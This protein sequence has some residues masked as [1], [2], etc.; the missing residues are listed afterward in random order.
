MKSG[1]TILFAIGLLFTSE[2]HGQSADRDLV[3]QAIEDYVD[4]LYLVQPEK[5]A[6]IGS[7]GIDEEGILEKI[8]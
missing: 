7:S 6:G 3:Y 1:I 5:I 2:A 4:A 8:G